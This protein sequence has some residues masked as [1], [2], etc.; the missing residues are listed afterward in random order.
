MGTFFFFFKFDNSRWGLWSRV[1]QP[2]DNMYALVIFFAFWKLVRSLS[3]FLI[4]LV[5]LANGPNIALVEWW[6]AWIELSIL[7]F[8]PNRHR[9]RT[10]GRPSIALGPSSGTPPLFVIP[11][12]PWRLAWFKNR[13]PC[14]SGVFFLQ[15]KCLRGGR[16]G[17]HA[18]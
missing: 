10:A 1:P 5:L 6:R 7:I 18:H 15:K 8:W 12:F 11:A 17:E 14:P 16:G 4:L 2:L 13:Q 3:C 9:R